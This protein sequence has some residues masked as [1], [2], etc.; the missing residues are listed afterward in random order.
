MNR[1]RYWGGEV[2][3]GGAVLGGGGKAVNQ[4]AVLGGLYSHYPHTPL[5][6][7]YRVTLDKCESVMNILIILL[8]NSC[9]R[10]QICYIK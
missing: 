2:V 9:I 5:L 8:D 6:S 3:N 7:M 10:P 1:G 4:G